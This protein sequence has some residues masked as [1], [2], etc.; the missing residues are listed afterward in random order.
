MNT[1]W[2]SKKKKKILGTCWPVRFRRPPEE[3][4]AVEVAGSGNLFYFL[5]M[6]TFCYPSLSN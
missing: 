5:H 1:W 4:F 6:A 2:L 3:K